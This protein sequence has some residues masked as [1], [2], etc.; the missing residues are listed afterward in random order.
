M[1]WSAPP[2]Q[3]LLLGRTEHLISSPHW[4]MNP[5]LIHIV[6]AVLASECWWRHLKLHI[7]SS[8][9]PSICASRS[10]IHPSI[11]PSIHPFIHGLCAS[12]IP[13][14]T[15]LISSF[16]LSDDQAGWK[17]IVPLQCPGC[18]AWGPG[19]TLA[20]PSPNC[21]VYQGKPMVGLS[22]SF[23]TPKS[24]SHQSYLA[25]RHYTRVLFG[26]CVR[27]LVGQRPDVNWSLRLVCEHIPLGHILSMT[28]K[29][30]R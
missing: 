24:T 5:G 20:E 12:Y 11:H 1:T 9:H 3:V 13:I 6:A 16:H 19:L 27:W 25:T 21:L 7:H 29:D 30:G 23:W 2:F 22:P 10:Y 14:L 18:T 28:R 15:Y 8:I 26:S 4:S 17:Y